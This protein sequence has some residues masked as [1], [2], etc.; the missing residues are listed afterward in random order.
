MESGKSKLVFQSDGNIVVYRAD[1][2]A[3]WSSGRGFTGRSGE[4]IMQLTAVE[5][6]AFA[7]ELN[8]ETGA[9]A[10]WKIP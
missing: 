2:V 1:N 10:F 4:W 7:T 3:L 9:R 5:T 6:P 8:S